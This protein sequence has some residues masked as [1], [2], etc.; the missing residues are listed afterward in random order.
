[1]ERF[2]VMKHERVKLSEDDEDR[3]YFAY[4][5]VADIPDP[6]HPTDR[7]DGWRQTGSTPEGMKQLMKKFRVM[8][9]TIRDKEGDAE[10]DHAYWEDYW[11]NYDRARGLSHHDKR[12][13]AWCYRTFYNK[14][15]QCRVIK[16]GERYEAESGFHR[17]W[18]AKQMGFEVLPVWVFEVDEL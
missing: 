6:E 12:S 9:Q 2:S 11:R 14:Y 13:M 15:H 16:C 18:F 10:P 17:T 1:M 8:M 5:K 3:G 7:G 4:V